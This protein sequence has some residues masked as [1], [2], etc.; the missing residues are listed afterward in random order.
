[1]WPKLFMQLFDLLPHAARL[2]PVADKFFAQRSA[3]DKAQREA[4]ATMAEEMHGGLGQVTRA[5]DS[6]Y[7]QLQEQNNRLAELNEDVRSARTAVQIIV[8][9]L[10][11][12]IWLLARA[13]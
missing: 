3:A 4:F 12:V 9:L 11:V 10:A 5:H 8:V 13:R 6:L 2:V 7:R 1:M